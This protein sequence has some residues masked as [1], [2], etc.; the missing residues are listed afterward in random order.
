MEKNLDI[1]KI[2]KK[3][4]FTK[5]HNDGII[6]ENINLMIAIIIFPNVVNIKS[7]IVLSFVSRFKTLYNNFFTIFYCFWYKNKLDN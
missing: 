2:V 7:N 4:A 3:H 1:D 5:N 6:I